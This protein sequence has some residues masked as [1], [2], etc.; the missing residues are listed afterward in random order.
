L[1]VIIFGINKILYGLTRPLRIISHFIF[2]LTLISVILILHEPSISGPFVRWFVKPSALF[3]NSADPE[4]ARGERLSDYYG[5]DQELK[6]YY[7]FEENLLRTHRFYQQNHDFYERFSKRIRN[8]TD[9]P[10]STVDAEKY[11]VLQ[12]IANYKNITNKPNIKPD[13]STMSDPGFLRD[14]HFIVDHHDISHSALYMDRDSVSVVKVQITQHTDGDSD[15]WLAH[16]L[17]CVMS[18]CPKYA[19]K[20]SGKKPDLV[21]TIKNN[22]IFRAD[23]DF[24]SKHSTYAWTHDNIVVTVD[25]SHGE[26]VNLQPFSILEAYLDKFPSTI[27][28]SYED[29]IQEDFWNK[30]NLEEMRRQL[31]LSN[32]WLSQLQSNDP[33][34][35]MILKNTLFHAFT[36]LNSRETVYKEMALADKQHIWKLYKGRDVSQIKSILS[37]FDTRL[38][39][40]TYNR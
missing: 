31:W 33:E 1:L 2:S 12:A 9:M 20:P 6:D 10:E 25:W 22:A 40:A 28:L 34:Y 11:L 15:K 24:R 39:L 35:D 37:Q 36:F 5:F 16:E 7:H 29:Y 18:N 26:K 21:T 27:K 23:D 38:A 14:V 17:E 8:S 30:W 13:L 19:D 3:L 4:I 32:K